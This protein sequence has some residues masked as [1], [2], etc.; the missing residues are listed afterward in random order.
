MKKIWKVT[1]LLCAL[2][3]M[4]CTISCKK[5]GDGTSDGVVSNDSNSGITSEEIKEA[6]DNI[7]E[8]G[9]YILAD[10]ENYKQCAQIV[11]M[12]MFGK[13]IQSTDYVTHGKQSARLE[14]LGYGVTPPAMTVH[15]DEDFFQKRDFSDCD[16][17]AF[18]LYSTM[19][20]DITMDFQIHPMS[21]VTYN[22][23]LVIKPGW[24]YYEIKKSDLG[25][26]WVNE[27]KAFSFLFEYGK[28]HEE[29]Q[30]F[31]IDNFRARRIEG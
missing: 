12:E 17:F 14:I 13:V 18:D 9:Y 24:N 29:T 7:F 31:Y 30:V 6:E 21:G 20:Y 4:L 26:N 16:M 19:N 23:D 8:N 25:V 11:Q 15:T 27:I 22:V 1:T 3:S 2:I 10:W 28:L 5:N